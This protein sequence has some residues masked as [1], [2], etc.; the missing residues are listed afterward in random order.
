MAD[1]SVAE[2]EVTSP[3]IKV[4]QLAGHLYYLSATTRATA[5]MCKKKKTGKHEPESGKG[6]K[7]HKK[8]AAN[9]DFT[10]YMMQKVMISMLSLFQKV[11]SV[12]LKV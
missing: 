5:T 12:V 6:N 3:E 1:A 8:Q 9:G 10:M 4:V 2:R 11:M 7:R